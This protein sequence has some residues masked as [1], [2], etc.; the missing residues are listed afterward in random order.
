MA[1]PKIDEL[2]VRVICMT[3]NQASFITDTL[4]G[5]AIQKTV[6]PFVCILLEDASTDGEPRVIK[7]YLSEH[8]DLADEA[9]VRREDTDDYELTFARHKTNHN[10]YFAA[11]LLSVDTN[12][13][14]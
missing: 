4:D 14:I 3:Y 10:C 1:F 12:R 13:P 8:F 6:F 2:R 9:I 7:D 11:F 5:F